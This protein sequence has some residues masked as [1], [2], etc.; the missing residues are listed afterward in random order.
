MRS[1][2]FFTTLLIIFLFSF[3][4]QA[5]NG[6]SFHVGGVFPSGDF[7]DDDYYKFNYEA[8]DENDEFIRFDEEGAADIGINAGVKYVFPLNENGLGVFVGAD[9]CYN[10]LTKDAQEDFEEDF[11]DEFD[12]GS[13]DYSMDFDVT[14]LKYF[15]IP[16]SGGLSYQTPINDQIIFFGQAGLTYNISKITDFELDFSFYESNE[17]E[18]INYTFDEKYKFDPSKNIGFKLGGGLMYKNILFELNYLS[19]G[20]QDVDIDWEGE[21]DVH[22]QSE[23]YEEHY[24]MKRDGKYDLDRKV[25]LVTFTVGYKF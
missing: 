4:S 2:L 21:V 13:D 10:K 12:L 19:L 9:F 5:Q 11:L 1:K 24:N 22:F 23:Y 15:N 18:S 8:E 20:S 25:N 14:Y 17:Y 7:A 6:F 16:I 3:N